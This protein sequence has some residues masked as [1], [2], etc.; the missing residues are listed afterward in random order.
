LGTELAATPAVA[1]TMFD[2]VGG[3]AL[4][5]RK[6]KPQPGCCTA[7]AGAFSGHRDVVQRGGGPMPG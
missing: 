4:I 7:Q 5:I 3:R 2:T 1:V 6:K